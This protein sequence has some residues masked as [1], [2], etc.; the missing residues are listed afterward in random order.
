MRKA[1]TELHIAIFLAG[2]TGLLGRLITLNEGLLVAYRMVMAALVLWLVDLLSG[3]TLLPGKKGFWQMMGAGSLIA[4]HWVFFYGS[5]KY[6]NVSIGL[7]CFSAVS[8]F[9]AFLDPLITRRRLDRMEVALG[10]AVM[11]GIYLIFH[12]EARYATGIL[13]G[14]ISSFLCTLFVILSKDILLRNDAYTVTRLEMTGGAITLLVLMPAYLHYFPCLPRICVGWFHFEHQEAAICTE[15]AGIAACERA[16]MVPIG[17]LQ[18]QRAVA[19]LQVHGIGHPATVIAD[20]FLTNALPS[21]IYGMIKG[22]LL[23][24]GNEQQG[25]AEQEEQRFL[26]GRECLFAKDN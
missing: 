19:F 23:G 5:I 22:L 21:V 17:G 20:F 4:L 15:C 9:T 25:K 1:F 24:L 2:I 10:L 26:H 14:I 18:H 3:R 12:F 7:V 6:A 16:F 13:L 8:F 11:L